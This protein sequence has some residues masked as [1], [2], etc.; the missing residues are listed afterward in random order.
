MP[1]QLK[2][3]AFLFLC[4]WLPP[5]LG[6]AQ[7]APNDTIRLGSIEINGRVYP[8]VFLPEATCRAALM[9]DEQR[10]KMNILRTNVHATYYYALAAAE[11][12]KK[13]NADLEKQPDRRS[14]KKYLKSIDKELDLTFKQPLK[15]L[16]I[17]QGHVLIKLIE[18]QTGD[19]CY[20]LIKE[21]KGGLSAMLWQSAGVFFNNNLVKEYD[22]EGQDKE[23]E[24]MVREL[25]ASNAYQYQLYLQNEMMKRVGKR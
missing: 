17:D 3:I 14:R 2:Y 21:L 9:N 10:K 25:E 13:I 1:K 23:L 22:P 7:N 4:F 19:N 24:A 16:S 18:R 12:F 5:Q 11:I 8:F 6:L 20:H 15:N